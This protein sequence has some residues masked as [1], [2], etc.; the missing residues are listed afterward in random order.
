MK[1]KVL[2][3]FFHIWGILNNSKLKVKFFDSSFFDLPHLKLPSSQ[4]L[5][6]LSKDD[7][8]CH[9]QCFRFEA[10]IVKGKSTVPQNTITTYVEGE[11]LQILD[12]QFIRVPIQKKIM[13]SLPLLNYVCSP[14]NWTCL[15]CNKTHSNGPWRAI[16]RMCKITPNYMKLFSGFMCFIVNNLLELRS[17][18]HQ[19]SASDVNKFDARSLTLKW[20]CNPILHHVDMRR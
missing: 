18:L 9:L 7:M 11:K 1:P 17:Y 20:V 5:T 16:I 15:E 12:N 10:Y 8:M 4:E 13:V 14:T 3:A 2:L 6:S 19:A